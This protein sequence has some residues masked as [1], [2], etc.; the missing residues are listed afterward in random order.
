DALASGGRPGDAGWGEEPPE[1]WGR[2]VTDVG[3][4][5]VAGTVE[6]LPGAYEAYYAQVRDALAGQAPP[7]VD[8]EDSIA[9][10]RIIESARESARTGAVV[11]V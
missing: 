2:L 7:P 9:V 4:L 8:P 1:R 5:M 3:G 11:R 6:T 10:L